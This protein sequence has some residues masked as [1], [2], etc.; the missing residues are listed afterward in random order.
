MNTNEPKCSDPEWG[1]G[2][3]FSRCPRCVIYVSLQSP[4]CP[5]RRPVS[6]LHRARPVPGALSPTTQQLPVK[7]VFTHT[8]IH[9]QGALPP[10][11]GK[12]SCL[13]GINHPWSHFN[14]VIHS[15]KVGRILTE[16]RLQIIL[17]KYYMVTSMVKLFILIFI[18]SKKRYHHII[19]V[20]LV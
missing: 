2:R 10:C 11:G 13:F 17:L 3:C 18:I 6:A 14:N 16:L 1:P 5:A 8:C 19:P 20:V 9:V 15:C 4:P 12:A 7:R